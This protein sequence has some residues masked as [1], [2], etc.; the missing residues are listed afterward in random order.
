MSETRSRSTTVELEDFRKRL[1]K[2]EANHQQ[3]Q[4]LHAETHEDGSTALLPARRVLDRYCICART[5][6]R[7]V[8]DE[9]V[10]FPKPIVVHRR[11]YWRVG[12]LVAFE[13]RRSVKT[14]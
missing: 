11:R 3:P 14:S 12:E 10:G 7:W 1:E 2:L 8:K 4:L 9:S 13:R 5:L 6:D